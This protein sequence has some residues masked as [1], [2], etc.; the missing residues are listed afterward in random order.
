[1]EPV[2][3]A[4]QRPMAR[5]AEAR[6]TARR[7]EEPAAQRPARMASVRATR[8]EAL[9]TGRARYAPGA[10]TECQASSTGAGPGRYTAV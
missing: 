1:M 4:R 10:F 8:S 2:F 7:P 5:R 9:P 3:R 6:R